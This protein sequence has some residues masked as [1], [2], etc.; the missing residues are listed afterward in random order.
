MYCVEEG[1][2]VK[3]KYRT[4]ESLKKQYSNGY[5]CDKCNNH[6]VNVGSFHC[7]N[8]DQHRKTYGDPVDICPDCY[9]KEDSVSIKSSSAKPIVNKQSNA[10]NNPQRNIQTVLS[11]LK[12]LIE[13][14]DE[15]TVN[16]LSQLLSDNSKIN[17][18]NHNQNVDHP[19]IINS[20]RNHNH[21]VNNDNTAP[22][23]SNT[24]H[25]NNNSI[26]VNNNDNDE[27]DDIP[28]YTAFGL[29]P[30]SKER[31]NQ[32]KMGMFSHIRVDQMTNPYLKA[33]IALT[34]PDHDDRVEEKMAKSCKKSFVTN[35]EN[36]SGE[37]IAY[38]SAIS[39]FLQNALAGEPLTL[40]KLI[41]RSLT[42]HTQRIAAIA[43]I[44]RKCKQLLEKSF[45][46]ITINLKELIIDCISAIFTLNLGCNICWATS[47]LT[48][49][50]ETIVNIRQLLID[51]LYDM[52]FYDMSEEESIGNMNIIVGNVV[53]GYVEC[54]Q[55]LQVRH[56]NNIFTNSN[57]FL[58]CAK[59]AELIQSMM[60]FDKPVELGGD[61]RRRTG[62]N[63]TLNTDLNMFVQ[64]SSTT[65][66]NASKS[67]KKK[68]NMNSVSNVNRTV[69]M[70][71]EELKS[72]DY[73][74][75]IE[76]KKSMLLLLPLSLKCFPTM[77]IDRYQN[78]ILILSMC[79]SLSFINRNIGKFYFLILS[80]CIKKIIRE[81][82]AV[83]C[84]FIFRTIINICQK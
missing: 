42:T 14:K 30:Q 17:E 41:R 74:Q 40:Y 4:F 48:S 5:W 51:E 58:Q 37:V 7:G 34:A 9:Y 36:V 79:I 54:A 63:M 76:A 67:T 47:D 73:Y 78:I 2:D 35:V 33:L 53:L 84:K 69:E 15:E 21:N 60:S 59:F 45:V 49:N 70:V 39:S 55:I 25:H 3:L 52:G 56:D 11:N 80:S 62:M 16:L 43:T 18:N 1:C 82:D 19:Q 13:Q 29:S 50:K 6:K 20:N 38:T 61:T 64:S 22:I 71:I 24:N 46:K 10:V 27:D 32:I 75:K 83:L 65:Q 66:S 12:N 8:V 28:K 57:S 26:T 81:F 23:N 72:I 68:K 31:L 77:L 44:E